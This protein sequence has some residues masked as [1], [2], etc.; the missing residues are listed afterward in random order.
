MNHCVLGAALDAIGDTGFDAR[1]EPEEGVCC[2]KPHP[3]S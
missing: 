2:V 3:T 1:L